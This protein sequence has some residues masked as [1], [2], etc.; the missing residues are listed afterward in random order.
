MNVL[1]CVVLCCGDLGG[2]GQVEKILP[3]Y[4]I[5]F[6]QAG[7]QTAFGEVLSVNALAPAPRPLISAAWRRDGLRKYI[8]DASTSRTGHQLSYKQALLPNRADTLNTASEPQDKESKIQ[9]TLHE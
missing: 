7:Q 4:F 1:K 8:L 2:K 5:V 3:F 9:F 6:R